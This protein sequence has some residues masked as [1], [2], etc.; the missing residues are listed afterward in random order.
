MRSRPTPNTSTKIGTARLRPFISKPAVTSFRPRAALPLTLTAEINPET[1]S[2]KTT[3]PKNGKAQIISLAPLLNG[4]ISISDRKTRTSVPSA[5]IPV[6]NEKYVFISPSRRDGLFLISRVQLQRSCPRWS[7]VLKLNQV[8]A[9][10]GPKPNRFH[11][12]IVPRSNE[13]HGFAFGAHED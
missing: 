8:F 10:I 1:P 7:L 2:P 5:M 13:T 9:I 12:Q 6:I 3:N 11:L 4:R